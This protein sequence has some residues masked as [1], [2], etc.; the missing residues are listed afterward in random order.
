MSWSVGYDDKWRRFVGYGVTA[1]CDYP[2]CRKEINRGLPYV[3]GDQPP[4]YNEHGCGLHFCD[5]HMHY[6]E[7]KKVQL[8]G[9]CLTGRPPYKPKHEHPEW[10]NHI[11]TDDSWSDWREKNPDMVNEYKTT[12]NAT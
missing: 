6:S 4:G 5:E 12:V 11:L 1:Y 8:C 9:K 2:K 7:S 10:V 3:C